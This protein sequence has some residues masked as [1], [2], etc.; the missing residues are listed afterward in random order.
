MAGNDVFNALVRAAK[1]GRLDDATF[2]VTLSGAIVNAV[3][4]EGWSALH[5]AARYGSLGVVEMLATHGADV[6]ALTNGGENALMLAAYD[7]HPDICT[8]LAGKAVRA[9]V[10]CVALLR[11]L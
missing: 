9:S 6:H 10:G 11:G 8:Y 7:D 5:F 3:N 1:D 4:A 2:F